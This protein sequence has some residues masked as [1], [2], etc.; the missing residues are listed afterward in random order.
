[1]HNGGCSLQTGLAVSTTKYY[2]GVLLT[3]FQIM[4][5]HQCLLRGLLYSALR[6]LSQSGRA[7]GRPKM[8]LWLCQRTWAHNQSIRGS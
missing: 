8:L 7:P 3:R 6:H 5:P 1:M 4:V 2:S